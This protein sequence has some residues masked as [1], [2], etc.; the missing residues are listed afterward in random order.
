M[1]DEPDET[2]VSAAGWSQIMRQGGG[3][4]YTDK[5]VRYDTK[6]TRMVLGA[7]G[8]SPSKVSELR[9]QAPS[10]FGLMKIN[11]EIFDN[12]IA[13]ECRKVNRPIKL[14]TLIKGVKGKCE[15]WELFTEAKQNWTDRQ[16]VGVVFDWHGDGIPELIVHDSAALFEQS[17]GWAMRF[18]RAKDGPYYVQDLKAFLTVLGDKFRVA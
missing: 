14:E 16:A 8:L 9:A 6:I 1:T 15:W 2:S 5:N 11:N 3:T 4:G 13:L 12:T 10:E 7:I 18:Y 17:P